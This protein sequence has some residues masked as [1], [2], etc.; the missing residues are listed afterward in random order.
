MN[1]QRKMFMRMQ[2]SILSILMLGLSSC[3]T[4]KYVLKEETPR[5][6]AFRGFMIHHI[7]Q[8]NTDKALADLRKSIAMDSSYGFAYFLRGLVYVYNERKDLGEKDFRRAL[9]RIGNNSR[10]P[11]GFY[12]YIL[13]D[14]EDLDTQIG[15]DSASIYL[16]LGSMAESEEK[17]YTA[18]TYYHAS[19]LC[20]DA[21][22]IFVFSRMMFQYQ[23]RDMRDSAYAY[24]KARTAEG[25]SRDMMAYLEMKLMVSE[26]AR[27]DNAIQERFRQFEVLHKE[28]LPLLKIR[29][30]YD[31]H[32][33]KNYT[34]A[35]QIVSKIVVQDTSARW[36]KNKGIA[37]YQ[38]EKYEEAIQDFTMCFASAPYEMSKNIAVCYNKLHNYEKA[39]FYFEKAYDLLER[40][41]K[42]FQY[43]RY[44]L[45][46]SIIDAKSKL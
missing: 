25:A 44:L 21:D 29:F 19:L 22:S 13:S 45:D 10:E 33:L 7:A 9:E 30:Q 16:I 20:S 34:R 42:N 1:I 36:R 2:L 14:E 6:Y 24:L 32:T 11:K 15:Y 18:A 41:H 4:T 5:E 27:N 37:S 12:S 31:Y 40:S 39:L 43:E 35:Y 23:R 26:K 3:D 38:L 17:H 46:N 8:S 28:Y